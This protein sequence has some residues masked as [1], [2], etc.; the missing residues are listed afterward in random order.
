V[1]IRDF[2]GGFHCAS[3][4]GRGVEGHFWRPWWAVEKYFCSQGWPGASGPLG[5]LA[6]MKIRSCDLEGQKCHVVTG[7]RRCHVMR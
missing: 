4:G 6:K 1:E 7:E 5:P 2:Q 3:M